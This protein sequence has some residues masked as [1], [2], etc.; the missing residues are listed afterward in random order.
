MNFS[1]D[2]LIIAVDFDGTIVKDA[3]PKIGKPQIFAFETLKNDPSLS[4]AE[5]IPVK[6]TY[7]QLTKYKN[8]W[9]YIS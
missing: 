6:S 2:T 8:I 4:L 3:Y 5:N 9:N 7:I 1:L